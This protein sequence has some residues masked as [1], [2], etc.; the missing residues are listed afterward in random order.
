MRKPSIYLDSSFISSFWFAGPNAEGQVRRR[1]SRD[2]WAAE[3]R[4]FDLWGSAFVVAE[5]Q[6]GIY[7]HQ[8]ESVRMSR[9]LKFCPMRGSVKRCCQNLLETGLIPANK[10]MDAWHLSLSV[11]HEMDYLLT[12]NYA[13]LANSAAQSRLNELCAHLQL[14]APLLVSPESIPQVRFGQT[15]IRGDRS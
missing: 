13:H 9:S 8:V 6:T 1:N 5:L 2:W 12:W 4:V 15:V 14:R 3:R 11:C 7:R 10:P